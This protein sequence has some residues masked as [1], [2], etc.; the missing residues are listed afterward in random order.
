MDF[1]DFLKELLGVEGWKARIRK[2]GIL[3]NVVSVKVG[4]EETNSEFR[5]ASSFKESSSQSCKS[6]KL[7][8]MNPQPSISSWVEHNHF[9]WLEA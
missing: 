5:I 8:M 3:E 9:L 4:V 7:D 2:R 1:S 6:F